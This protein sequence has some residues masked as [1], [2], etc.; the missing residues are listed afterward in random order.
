MVKS[1]KYRLMRAQRFFIEPS[2]R[3]RFSAL[4]SPTDDPVGI[5]PSA[6]PVAK[7]LSTT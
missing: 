6:E 2:V 7:T 3:H 5:G 4:N 1:R